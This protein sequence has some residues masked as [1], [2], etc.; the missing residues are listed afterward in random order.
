MQHKYDKG[1]FEDSEGEPYERLPKKLFKAVMFA[2]TMIGQ[3]QGFRKSV[4]KA[5]EY[6]EVDIREVEKNVVLRLQVLPIDESE[7]DSIRELITH[8]PTPEER[9]A[10][11]ELRREFPVHTEVRLHSEVSAGLTT[12]TYYIT[13]HFYDN[14]VLA[15]RACP[16]MGSSERTVV[17]PEDCEIVTDAVVI[18][19]RDRAAKAR[20][21]V[22]EEA[23]AERLRQELEEHRRRMEVLAKQEAEA[24]ERR[25]QGEVEAPDAGERMRLYTAGY[26]DDEIAET[27]SLTRQQVQLWRVGNRLPMQ[28]EV[29]QWVDKR[30][31]PTVSNRR[32]G[33]DWDIQAVLESVDHL[34]LRDRDAYLMRCAHRHKTRPRM[35]KPHSYSSYMSLFH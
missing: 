19:L 11:A 26:Y 13:S 35:Q 17:Y 31:K 10:I 5:A 33:P 3:G 32:Y 12:Q 29:R 27:L 22:E 14:G 30:A 23:R 7:L 25:I 18:R 20:M 24:R 15:M 2:C 4:I 1:L 28:S 9:E 16:H 8:D 34:G 6:Y 21:R